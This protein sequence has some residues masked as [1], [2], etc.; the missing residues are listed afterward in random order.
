MRLLISGERFPKT[1][2]YLHEVKTYVFEHLSH[3]LTAIEDYEITGIQAF[4]D[5]YPNFIATTIKNKETVKN[6][7]TTLKLTKQ[8]DGFWK[9]GMSYAK[10]AQNTITEIKGY[11]GTGEDVREIG[12]KIIDLF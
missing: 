1:T 12:E 7:N 6:D 3:I 5:N 2:N 9:K 8:I 4:R 11:L 10:K